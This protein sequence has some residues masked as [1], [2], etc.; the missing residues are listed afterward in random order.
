MD[1]S[2]V[3]P[4]ICQYGIGAVLCMVGLWAGL[5]GR[6]LDLRLADDRRLVAVLVGGYLLMLALVCVF[7]FWAPFWP[8]GAQP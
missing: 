6:Y 2:R 4:L 7:T 3:W 8:E 5:R 1:M